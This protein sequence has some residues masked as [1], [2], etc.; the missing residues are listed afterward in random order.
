MP[1]RSSKI[2]CEWSFSFE[3]SIR[4][5]DVHQIVRTNRI[6]IESSDKLLTR[7][8]RLHQKQAKPEA[9]PDYGSSLFEKVPTEIRY[10]IYDLL[11]QQPHDTFISYPL[12]TRGPI[13][14]LSQ[15]C[16]GIRK[17]IT[18]WNEDTPYLRDKLFGIVN[19]ATATVGLRINLSVWHLSAIRPYRFY[20]FLKP[21]EGSDEDRHVVYRLWHRA[22]CEAQC[23]DFKRTAEHLNKSIGGD[24]DKDRG[25]NGYSFCK[26]LAPVLAFT[27]TEIWTYRHWPHFR[28]V[29]S[30]QNDRN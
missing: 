25:V 20:T 15:T 2:K 13:E 27:R 28:R 30:L 7:S 22:L 10:M 17:D 12:P 19:P 4:F 21:F 8:T 14:P 16:R 3:S 18:K 29:R 11:F 5:L 26:A 23:L 24:S 6:K 1:A 9:H